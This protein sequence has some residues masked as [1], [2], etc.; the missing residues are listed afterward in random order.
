VSDSPGASPSRGVN[1]GGEAPGGFLRGTARSPSRSHCTRAGRLFVRLGQR[2]VERARGANTP[3]RMVRDTAP[4]SVAAACAVVHSSAMSTP[5][6]R[7][8]TFTTMEASTQDDWM[9]IGA[10]FVGFAQKLPD[11]ISR[12]CACSTAITA[13]LPS[14]G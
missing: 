9:R 6:A 4:Q 5:S 3:G 2:I 12:I 13:A 8:A 10:E 1:S 11:R 14:I 7:G